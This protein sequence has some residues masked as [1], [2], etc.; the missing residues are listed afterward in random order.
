MS[1]RRLRSRPA[2]SGRSGS[3][4]RR[5][6]QSPRT[7]RCWRRAWASTFPG[8]IVHDLDVR[9]ERGPGVEALEEVVR[10]ERV[11]GDAALQRGRERV[12]VV[13]PF[14]REDA[15]AEEVL[16]RVRDRRRVRVDAGVAREDAREARRRGARRRDRDARLED[17]VTRR[18]RAASRGRDAAGSAGARGCRRAC[19]PR[20]AGGAC[21]CRASGRSEPRGGSRGRRPAGRSSCP[22]RRAGAGSAPRAFRAS[23]P[24]PSR[25]PRSDSSGARGGRERS[26]PLRARRSGPRCPRTRR[27]ESRRR[28][29]ASASTASVKSESRAK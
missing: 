22:S 5:I 10:E 1:G 7:Q 6:C 13:E 3:S 29:A 18:S 19:A 23:S 4:Q 25:G 12:D 24:I 20:R 27:R 26:A 9:D 11:L 17:A 2:A 21:R 28:R 16:V 15:L 8:I 14:P